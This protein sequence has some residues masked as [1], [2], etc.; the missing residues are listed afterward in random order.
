[1]TDK[2]TVAETKPLTPVPAQAGQTALK[3]TNHSDVTTP[4][5]VSNS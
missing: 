2:T 1:M 4:V 3:S 5:E